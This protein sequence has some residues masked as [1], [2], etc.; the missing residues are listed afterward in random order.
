MRQVIQPGYL[1]DSHPHVGLPAEDRAERGA[2][3][4]RRQVAGADLVEQRLERVIVMAV[5]D[6][7]VRVGAAQRPGRVQPGETAAD[8]HNPR[9]GAHRPLSLSCRERRMPVSVLST[10]TAVSDVEQ[11]DA[12]EQDQCDD[13]GHDD[14]DHARPVHGTLPPSCELSCFLRS[15]AG[16]PGR[17]NAVRSG[18]ASLRRVRRR[19]HRVLVSGAGRSAAAS[20]WPRWSQLAANALTPCSSSVWTTSS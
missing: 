14:E 19:C 15:A 16:I 13:Y 7:D 9:A 12:R 5:D 11:G 3:F 8:D 18:I 10:G 2:D 1:T 17:T 6:R 4:F 20:R